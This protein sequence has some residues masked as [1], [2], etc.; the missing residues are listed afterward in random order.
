MGLDRSPLMRSVHKAHASLVSCQTAQRTL[1]VA[2]CHA[3][4]SVFTPCP[5]PPAIRIH[6]LPFLHQQCP[7]LDPRLYPPS[8]F[9]QLNAVLRRHVSRDTGGGER[10]DADTGTYTTAHRSVK[11]HVKSTSLPAIT[12][13]A[14]VTHMGAP[15]L[16]S[17]AVPSEAARADKFLSG[18][19]KRDAS[20]LR[21]KEARDR[22][23]RETREDHYVE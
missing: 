8:P 1:A 7:S 18:A 11:Q 12:M 15:Q 3:L 20:A 4:S 22:Q 21:S 14:S 2:A 6:T 23:A 10:Y 9:S 17:M 19:D 16:I 13:T 5:S